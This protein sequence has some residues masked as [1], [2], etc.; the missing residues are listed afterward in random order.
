MLRRLAAAGC[1]LVFAFTACDGGDNQNAATD[2]PA[3]AT[4][5]PTPCSI[6]DGT[7]DPKRSDTMPEAAPLRELRYS[8]RSDEGCPRVVFAFADHT[9]GYLVR[10]VDGPFSECGSGEPVATD[11]WDATAY[12]SVRLE[13]SGSADLS[14]PDAPQTYTGPRDIEVGGKVLKHLRVICDFEAVFEWIVAVDEEHK[15]TVFT[16]DD[17]SRIVIDVS[18]T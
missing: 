18:E 12:L 13:P 8:Q 9:P 6:A 4:P 15:F 17:P 2:R 1:V 16:L 14:K 11:S 7:L 10:Y 5:A 3:T